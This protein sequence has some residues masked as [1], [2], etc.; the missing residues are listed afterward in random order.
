MD[1]IS[2][3]D[4]V[5]LVLRQRLLERAR[6]GNASRN[7]KPDDKASTAPGSLDNLHA[8]AG[9]QDIEDRQLGRALIQSLLVEELGSELINDAK[10]QRTI[11]QVLETLEREAKTRQLLGRLVSELRTASR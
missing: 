7:Q 5:I 9:V 10:F 4:R 6:A 3:A 8:L 1:R 2:N 11:D